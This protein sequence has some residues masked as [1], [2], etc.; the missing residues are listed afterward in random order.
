[1]I[2]TIDT[3]NNLKNVIEVEGIYILFNKVKNLGDRWLDEVEYYYYNELDLDEKTVEEVV[4][5]L[6]DEEYVYKNM[7]HL[8]HL[9]LLDYLITNPD[10]TIIDFLEHYTN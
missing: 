3:L 9:Q 7:S 2:V 5:L 6:N 4:D 10:N 1:M 8:D